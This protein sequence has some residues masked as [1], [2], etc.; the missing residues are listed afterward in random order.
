ML[1]PVVV[2]ALCLLP[3]VMLSPWAL[4]VLLVPALVMDRDGR[5]L[6]DRAAG[7]VVVRT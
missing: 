2:L 3:V 5:G 4:L 1:L 6:H 7:A